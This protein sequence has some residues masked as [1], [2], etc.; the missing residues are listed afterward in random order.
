MQESLVFELDKFK[1]LELSRLKLEHN[2]ELRL[3]GAFFFYLSFSS[4]NLSFVF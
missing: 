2:A 1:T 4:V 3:A